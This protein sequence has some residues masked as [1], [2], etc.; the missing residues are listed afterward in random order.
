MS[1][2]N[3][4]VLKHN[5]IA[6]AEFT[7]EKLSNNVNYLKIIDTQFSPVNSNESEI[8][9]IVSF[10]KWLTDRC[11]SNSRDGVER[12]KKKYRI[13][14]MRQV[15]LLM[16]GLSLSD[17]YWIERK[18]FNNKWK[19]I[20][21]FENRYDEAI[22]SVL[23]DKKL[24]LVDN[25]RDYGYRNPDLTT[26]G[27]LRKYWRYNE[28]DKKSYLVKGGSKPDLQEPFN[29]YFAHLLLEELHFKHTP[30][31][32]EKEGGEY[33]S[34]CP[35]IADID[36]EMISAVDIQ[37]KYGIE[38]TYHGLLAL[39]GR[40]GC[41]GFDDEINKMIILDYLIDNIDR[42][43]HNFGILRNSQTG[44]WAGLIP[45]FDN[46]YS[47][48]NKDFV[49]S[50]IVSESMSFADSNEECMKL[51]DV[52]KYVQS[53]PDMIG[54]FDTAFSDYPNTERRGKIRNG[55]SERIR[56]IELFLTH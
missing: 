22:G 27:S 42:H 38:K 36:N 13:E 9:Q 46:G 48:W 2:D 19:D 56:D 49:D 51:V 39:A 41:A 5:D 26:G 1:S 29:E 7:V 3:E 12:L 11:I 15:M 17:H 18:P 45:V 23:F 54:I 43:W 8:S 55:L 21:L 30:Y 34:V 33:V 35:C 32:L 53:V 14:D 40:E 24:K 44:T 28:A 47:L 20:N 4:Y 25:I 52:H 10:N 37:R 50:R 16:Y 6:V 31:V